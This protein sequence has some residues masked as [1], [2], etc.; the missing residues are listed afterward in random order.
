MEVVL[1]SQTEATAEK[2]SVDT[3]YSAHHLG[4]NPRER[5]SGQDATRSEVK[6]WEI[7]DKV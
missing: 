3:L 7:D 5:K 6:V 4:E 1:G 2:L